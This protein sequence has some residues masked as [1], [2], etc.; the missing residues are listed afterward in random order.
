M[1]SNFHSSEN[2]NVFW[3]FDFIK[4]QEHQYYKVT[5]WVIVKDGD[6]FKPVSSMS[7]DG[8]NIP[9]TRI[10]RPD[11]LEVYHGDDSNVGVEFIIRSGKNI[12]V[13][14]NNIAYNC[15]KIDNFIAYYSGFS[16]DKKG[17]ITVD[18]FY[19]NPDFVRNYAINNLDFNNSNYHKGKRS[20]TRFILDGTKEKFEQII[21][22]KIINWNHEK[23][24]NGI[25]QYCTADDPIVYH[26]DSQT[27]AAMVFL[28]K[29][30]PFESG[31][32]FYSSKFTGRSR[33]DDPLLDAE[34]YE[35]TFKGKNSKLNFYDS[36]QFTKIDEIGNVYNRLVLFDS[37]TIHA[38]SKYFGD[39]IENARFFHLFFF[40]VI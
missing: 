22:R 24:A 34:A 37:K 36:T 40:D 7:V 28:T 30:A 27:Y 32:S 11:V 31:T 35:K 26:V 21:G 17:L 1:I 3:Y 13:V 5:G 2:E 39:S 16:N 4:H 15:G 33:F 14:Y 25:F 23:Y 9:L 18:N 38:A 20:T 19:Q 29:D 12:D 8:I 6:I 10:S